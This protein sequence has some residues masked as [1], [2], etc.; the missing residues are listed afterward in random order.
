MATDVSEL[1]RTVNERIEEINRV[2]AELEAVA[3]TPAT[4]VSSFITLDDLTALGLSFSDGTVV[5]SAPVVI[6]DTVTYEGPTT[7]VGGELAS[8]DAVQ[9]L[10]DS[11]IGDAVALTT[12]GEIVTIE[13][14]SGDDGD[15]EGTLIMGRELR[16]GKARFLHMVN[17]QLVVNDPDIKTLLEL[18]LQELKNGNSN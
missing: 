6:E 12:D 5:I 17:G 2:F 1:V 15:T 11:A 16:T 18:I 7:P 9:G 10:V 13:N 4:D 14:A 8:A 3:E